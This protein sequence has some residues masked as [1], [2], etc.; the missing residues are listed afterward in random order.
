MSFLWDR[1]AELT[2][3]TEQDRRIFS[4][5]RIAFEIEKTSESNHN[6]GKIEIYNLNETSRGLITS[7]K[8]NV[9]LEIGYKSLPETIGG[10]MATKPLKEIV[11]KGNCTKVYSEKRGIDFVTVFEFGDGATALYNATLDKSYAANIDSKVIV[12]ELIDS[13]GVVRGVVDQ[14]ISKVFKKGYVASGPSKDQ[15]DNLA[16]QMGYEWSIQDGELQFLQKNKGTNED[17]ILLSPEN[18][19]L[20][21]PIRKDKG[22]ELKCL[23]NPQIRPGRKIVLESRTL[24]G[25]FV[26]KKCNYVGD[27]R[28][29]EFVCKIE[30]V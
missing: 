16:K 20:A 12:N 21:T 15:L 23:L 19:L 18:G 6:K 28:H 1:F 25:T 10:A 4:D 24:N 13:L 3:D 8:P 11:C 26:T 27:N 7:I 17:A 9:I 5:F 29:G 2:V 14:T 30:A 22:I